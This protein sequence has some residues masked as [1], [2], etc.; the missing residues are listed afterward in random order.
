MSRG[1]TWSNKEIKDLT[2][3]LSDDPIVHHREKGMNFLSLLCPI[4]LQ[5][6]RL[7]GFV[8]KVWSK[9][10]P[11]KN[12]INVAISPF[13]E[14]KSPWLLCVKTILKVHFGCFV[15]QVPKY[16]KIISMMWWPGQCAHVVTMTH[17]I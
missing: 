16:Y 11:N 2:G 15:C 13:N 9:R 14:I 17:S 10:L 3:I 6:F 12:A 4:N 5:S 7:Y 1:Q 8:L